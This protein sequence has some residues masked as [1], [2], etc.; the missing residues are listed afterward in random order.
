[1]D[2][3]RLLPFKQLVSLST[4]GTWQEALWPLRTLLI[5]AVILVPT[6]RIVSDVVNAENPC[7]EEEDF[8]SWS[9]VIDIPVPST[10]STY[11]YFHQSV[12]SPHHLSPSTSPSLPIHTWNLSIQSCRL[13]L[14]KSVHQTIILNMQAAKEDSNELDIWRRELDRRIEAWDR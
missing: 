12:A 5:G 2:E 8:G 11:S 1:M 10:S 9:M 6:L 14:G 3:V 4:L 13:I 7:L